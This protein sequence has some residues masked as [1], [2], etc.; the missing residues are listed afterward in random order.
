MA[1]IIGLVECSGALKHEDIL[2]HHFIDE[3]LSIFNVNGTIRKIQKSKIL[4][5]LTMNVIP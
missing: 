3:C 5:K 1:S 4:Q 2:H